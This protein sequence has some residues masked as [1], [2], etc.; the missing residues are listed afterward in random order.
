MNLDEVNKLV[1]QLETD[2]SRLEGHGPDVQ[3]VKSELDALKRALASTEAPHHG[4]VREALEALEDRIDAT[5]ETARADAFKAAPYVA[6]IGR[7]LGLS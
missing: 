2:L 6:W 1:R 3:A 4:P 5:A 7:I